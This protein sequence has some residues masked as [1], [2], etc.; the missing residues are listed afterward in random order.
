MA[1]CICALDTWTTLA[2]CLWPDPIQSTPQANQ[3][4]TIDE[5]L[6]YQNIGLA[7]LKLIRTGFNRCLLWM[8]WQ[9][10]K[11]VSCLVKDLAS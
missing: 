3:A 1:L 2:N 10:L 4:S 7:L 8:M 6:H 5:L 9:A 11:A